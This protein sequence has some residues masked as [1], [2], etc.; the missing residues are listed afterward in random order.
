M[1]RILVW[2]CVLTTMTGSLV[3]CKK[4]K[5]PAQIT[6]TFVQAGQE[7]I[8]KTLKTGETLTDIPEAVQKEGYTVVWDR[9]DFSGLSESVTVTAIATPNTYTI[10]Y[11]VANDVKITAKV[12]EVTFDSEV[13]L[14]TPELK[15]WS[16]EGW[17]NAETGEAFESGKYTVA[18]D[19]TLKAIW[20]SASG[21]EYTPNK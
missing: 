13:A 4:S 20:D 7:N 8:E 19:I 17:Y 10:T 15:N 5:K 1:K 16:F 2:L 3:A 6:V 9:K 18:E 14:Y 21:L 11:A 12:Q